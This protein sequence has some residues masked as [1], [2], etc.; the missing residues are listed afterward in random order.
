MLIIMVESP[1]AGDVERNIIYARRA[2]RYVID[3]GHVPI[4][5]HLMYPQVMDD[6][7]PEERARALHMCDILR[8]RAHETWFFVDYGM[9]KGMKIA[10]KWCLDSPGIIPPHDFLTIGKNGGD[11]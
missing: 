2:M 11:Q 3:R 8:L 1:F 9:S 7:D 6:T 5:P 10:E 4:V